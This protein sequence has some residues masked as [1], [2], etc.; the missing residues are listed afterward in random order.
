[1]PEIDLTM[2]NFDIVSCIIS[3]VSVLIAAIA[4]ILTYKNLREMRKQFFELNRGRLVFYIDNVNTGLYHGLVIKNFGNSPAKL[5]SLCITPDLDWSKSKSTLSS[6]FNISNFKNV[7]LAPRQ[8]ASSAF[9][10]KDYPNDVFDVEITYETC[11]KTI[12]ESYVIDLHFSHIALSSSP[13]IKDE[14]NAL[15]EINNSI[16][17]LSQRFL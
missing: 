1:M 8:H 7:F 13:G 16:Q 5:L 11:G 14:L 2:I 3:A 17:Q 15:E 12:S 9:N 10:F 6:D 4:A